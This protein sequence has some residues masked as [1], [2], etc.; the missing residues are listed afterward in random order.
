[1]HPDLV[2]FLLAGA[3]V[4]TLVIYALYVNYALQ[5]AVRRAYLKAARQTLADAIAL[6]RLH[7]HVADPEHKH[8]YAE[9][10]RRLKEMP[11]E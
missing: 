9:L 3:V 11:L 7:E 10:Y 2:R 4:L 1:M 5:R 6:V 8:L